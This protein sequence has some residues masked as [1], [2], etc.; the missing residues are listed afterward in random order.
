MAET[1]QGSDSMTTPGGLLPEGSRLCLT[2]QSSD[3]SGGL[4]T[5]HPAVSQAPRTLGFPGAPPIH[6]TGQ[7]VADLNLE[8]SQLAGPAAFPQELCIR[9]H[10]AQY[11][12][13]PG[14][15]VRGT[16]PSSGI[17]TFSTALA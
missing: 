9:D 11:P 10:I 15:V 16:S 14:T 1:G 12:T 2:F 5:W 7:R 17:G 13:S 8:P 3:I 4:Q 6:R